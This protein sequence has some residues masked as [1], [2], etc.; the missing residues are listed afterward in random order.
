MKPFLLSEYLSRVQRR[1]FTFNYKVYRKKFKRSLLE[2]LCYNTNIQKLTKNSEDLP[3][4]VNLEW[5]EWKG[6][7]TLFV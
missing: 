2:I 6:L 4:R 5:K 7:A 1:F 3:V